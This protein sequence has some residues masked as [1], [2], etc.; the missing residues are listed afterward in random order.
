[1]KVR[2]VEPAL[3]TYTGVLYRISFTNG[4][5]DRELTEQEVSIIGAAMRVQSLEG[6]QVGA[7][8]DQIN[9]KAMTMD[10]A[11]VKNAKAEIDA[12]DQAAGESKTAVKDTAKSTPEPEIEKAPSRHYT[13]EEL[14]RIADQPG[15]DGGISGLRAIA[16]PMGVKGRSINELIREILAAQG[17]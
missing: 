17:E 16:A 3:N 13:R 4:V 11:K 10:R 9:A 8:V 1:M 14:E 12:A 6:E 7:G 2:I 5:S 15:I